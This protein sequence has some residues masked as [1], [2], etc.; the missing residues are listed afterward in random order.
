MTDL[1]VPE[2]HALL[3][4]LCFNCVFQTVCVCTDLSC[5]Y[6][7]ADI[8]QPKIAIYY[9]KGFILMNAVVIIV[10]FTL[11]ID[12]LLAFTSMSCLRSKQTLW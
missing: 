2:Q 4:S 12:L 9:E 3:D 1:I 6:C 7:L 11:H 5:F 8:E 10:L